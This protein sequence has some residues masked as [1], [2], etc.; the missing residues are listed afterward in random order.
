MFA[1]FSFS[2]S[3]FTSLK[4]RSCPPFGLIIW[5]TLY[6]R[7]LQALQEQHQKNR[8]NAEWQKLWCS[9]KSPTVTQS[10]VFAA[11]GFDCCAVSTIGAITLSSGRFTAVRKSDDLVIGVILNNLQARF[12]F[13][14]TICRA[15]DWERCRR[16][17]WGNSTWYVSIAS[18]AVSITLKSKRRREEKTNDCDEAEMSLRH[19]CLLLVNDN[20]TIGSKKCGRGRCRSYFYCQLFLV[21]AIGGDRLYIFTGKGTHA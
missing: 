2:T 3:L 18:A 7:T 6:K 17:D 19:D 10:S 8:Y 4:S 14:N 9:R 5:P 21:G 11:I 13:V 15:V 1:L 12:F 20:E 16:I